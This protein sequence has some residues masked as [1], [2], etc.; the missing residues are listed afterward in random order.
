MWVVRGDGWV[1]GD[2]RTMRRTDSRHW[3]SW[4]ASEHEVVV[5][6]AVVQGIRLS[7][8]DP[9]SFGD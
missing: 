8:G 9:R 4:M 3:A 5:F 6:P 2:T 7:V 1:M